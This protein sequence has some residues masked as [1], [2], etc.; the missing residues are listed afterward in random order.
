MEHTTLTLNLQYLSIRC[1]VR[2]N[3]SQI[4]GCTQQSND[5]LRKYPLIGRWIPL[6]ILQLACMHLT[7][8]TA[9]GCGFRD[10]YGSHPVAGHSS[11]PLNASLDWHQFHAFVYS[12]MSSAVWGSISTWGSTWTSRR[13]STW[14]RT[15][16]MEEYAPE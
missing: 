6:V 5:N 3:I 12:Q 10:Y 16:L 11:N 2:D 14:K 4:F 1:E 9:L 8:T 13:K 7:S 15:C